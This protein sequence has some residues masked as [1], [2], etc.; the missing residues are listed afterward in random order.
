[1]STSIEADT[2]SNAASASGKAPGGSFLSGLSISGFCLVAAWHFLVV[3][4]AVFDS[5]AQ[6]AVDGR[7]SPVVCLYVSLAISYLM[8]GFCGPLY[9][10]WFMD[11]S[12]RGTYITLGLFILFAIA[13][14]GFSLSG[15]SLPEEL[16]PLS[17]VALGFVTAIMIFPW[18]TSPL[19][20]VSGLSVFKNMA[21]NMGLGSVIALG[22]ICIPN[23]YCYAATF[24]LPAISGFVYLVDQI[25]HDRFGRKHDPWTEEMTGDQ[26][27]K[28]SD[29]I[30]PCML[31]FLYSVVF[32]FSQGSFSQTEGGGTE[33][34]L[35]GGWPALGATLSAAVLILLPKK[36]LERYGLMT[37]QQ[38]SVIIM[39]IGVF[40]AM[41][42]TMNSMEMDPLQV[43]AGQ[44][45][46]RAVTFAGFNVFEFGF[47][48]FAFA[49]ATKFGSN[50]I[51]FIGMNRGMLYGG[52]TLGLL[53]G[54]TLRHFLGNS[55]S[56]FLISS[57]IIVL[58]LMVYLMPFVT[59]V[60]PYDMWPNDS[61]GELD[62]ASIEPEFPTQPVSKSEDEELV[63]YWQAAVDDLALRHSLSKRE[64]EVFTYLARG[65]NA[66][67]IQQELFISIHTVK[68]H[69]ANIYRK[70]EVHS[71][72]E[73]LDI[74]ESAVQEMTTSK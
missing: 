29:M 57:A 54:E 59:D 53:A 9:R 13:A 62:G 28:I 31:F 64:R 60:V 73:V 20:S 5:S 10:K 40:M 15:T 34:I 36:Y 4:G 37:V 39:S 65:R 24:A 71:I 22:I 46:A 6:S 44:C 33:W 35:A 19:D 72:Q 1:M 56:L 42:F 69:I 11:Q 58:A 55:P 26:E 25:N 23:P 18:L 43:Q 8:I 51:P 63:D 50:L 68:T 12:K 21:F 3:F 17:Y 61:V 32:G 16:I 67:F 45:T 47:M 7:I 14:S 30:G 2:P 27:L 70:L 52:L 38:A 66:A 41:L 74:V 48:V 49:W